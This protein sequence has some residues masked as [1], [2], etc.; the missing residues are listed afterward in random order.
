[1]KGIG[2]RLLT[3]LV[4]AAVLCAS[5]A[6]VAGAYNTHTRNLNVAYGINQGTYNMR[7]GINAARAY[8]ATVVNDQTGKA[9]AALMQRSNS[10][11]ANAGFISDESTYNDNGTVRTTITGTT[12]YANYVLHSGYCNKMGQQAWRF[13]HKYQHQG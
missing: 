4:C 12:M 7:Y 13:D 9:Y 8:T 3:T 10:T 6:V 1:M 2:R 11:G 5:M